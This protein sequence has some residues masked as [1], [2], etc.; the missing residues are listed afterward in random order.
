MSKRYQH[1]MDCDA[2]ELAD[3]LTGKTAPGEVY[4]LTDGSVH[5]VSE[6]DDDGVPTLVALA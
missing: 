6:V 4:G 5:Y 3:E 2:A 1:F